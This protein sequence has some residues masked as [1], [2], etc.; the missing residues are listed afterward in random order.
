DWAGP[1]RACGARVY[2]LRPGE[3]RKDWN[4]ELVLDAASLRERLRDLVEQLRA[5]TPAPRQPVQRTLKSVPQEPDRINRKDA[6]LNAGTSPPR[7]H[8]GNRTVQAED[9]DLSDACKQLIRISHEARERRKEVG[10][11]Q[12]EEELREFDKSIGWGSRACAELFK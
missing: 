7:G 5:T 1:M 10:F 9:D 12:V 2:R 3:K 8:S 6:T 11:D 4:K